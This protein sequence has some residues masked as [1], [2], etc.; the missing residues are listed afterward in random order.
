MLYT[1]QKDARKTLGL[2][3]PPSIPLT[4]GLIQDDKEQA[5]SVLCRRVTHSSADTDAIFLY[6]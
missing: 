5:Y 4:V 6:F 2:T 3:V 1:C